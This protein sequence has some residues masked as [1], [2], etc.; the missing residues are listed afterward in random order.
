MITTIVGLLIMII[1]LI[2]RA[3]KSSDNGDKW[4]VFT[5]GALFLGWGSTGEYATTFGGV[6]NVFE[7]KIAKVIKH[8]LYHTRQYIYMH[9]WLGVF[10]FTFAALWGVISAKI[11][12]DNKG[13]PFDG[14]LAFRAEVNGASEVGNPIEAAAY[15]LAP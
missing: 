15:R 8:E 6:V 2:A 9:D 3:A 1:G 12:A 4:F 7:G 11:H 14:W 10:Y 5:G 13:V